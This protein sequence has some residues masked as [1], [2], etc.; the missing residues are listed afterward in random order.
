VKIH[1]GGELPTERYAR[2]LL[3]GPTG[4]GKSTFGSTM[5]RPRVVLAADANAAIPL[6]RSL[7][8]LPR[9]WAPSD[10]KDRR[11]DVFLQIE[12]GDDLADALEWI[13]VHLKERKI[14][15][16]VVDHLTALQDKVFRTVFEKRQA[17]MSRTAGPSGQARRLETMDMRGYG[18]IHQQLDDMR[19]RLH[20]LPCHVLWLSGFRPPMSRVD[21]GVRETKRG[22]P[23]LQGQQSYRFPANVMVSGY[24]EREGSD[25][26]IRTS[27][28][29][30][31]D[32]KD[33]SGTLD[34]V[35]LPD[36]MVMLARLGLLDDVT[37]AAVEKAIPRRTE[38]EKHAESVGLFI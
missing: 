38:D 12:D 22:G 8:E 35:E 4:S 37:A 13:E 14:A 11:P 3:F 30:D 21:N 5:P 9:V 27:P 6:H 25:V 29:R 19:I 17:S 23:D 36:A 26:L 16:V 31:I 18:L 34:T 10:E 20:A 15:S 24:I 1:T 28:W 32:A 33:N 2:I 7:E